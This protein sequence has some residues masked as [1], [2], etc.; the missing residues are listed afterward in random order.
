MGFVNQEKHKIIKADRQGNQINIT[1]H[2]K[3][4]ATIFMSHWIN[5]QEE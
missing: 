4:C 2:C 1:F 3:A 5:N